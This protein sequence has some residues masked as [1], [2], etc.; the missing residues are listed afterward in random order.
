MRAPLEHRGHRGNT[1]ENQV[2]G[3]TH[4]GNELPFLCVASV[5]SVLNDT[6]PPLFGAN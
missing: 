5:S 2:F 6:A 4:P 1:E 3:E